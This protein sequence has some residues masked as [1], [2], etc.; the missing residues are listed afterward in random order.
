MQSFIGC[1]WGVKNIGFVLICYGATDAFGSIIAGSIVKR[2]GR[3]P[4]FLFAACINLALIIT[5]LIW[6][7]TRDHPE[8]FFLI[9]AFWGLADAVWQTQINCKSSISNKKYYYVR[10]TQIIAF[11]GFI[12][13]T[14]EEAA[15]SNYRLWESIGFIIAYAYSTFICVNAKLYVLLGVLGAGMVG[16]LIIET[17]EYRRVKM[18]NSKKPVSANQN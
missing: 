2:T 8:A 6:E 18:Q 3:V 7:P 9:A 5:M 12:F 16:Y 11:Y 13:A 15:F 14:N 1:A 17:R 4:I 10:L